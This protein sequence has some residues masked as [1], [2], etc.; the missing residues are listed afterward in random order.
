MRGEEELLCCWLLPVLSALRGQREVVGALGTGD[1]DN[2]PS[3]MD[4]GEE[5][6]AARKPLD[7]ARHRHTE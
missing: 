1:Y 3:D 5:G 2:I 7:P 6:G 4:N